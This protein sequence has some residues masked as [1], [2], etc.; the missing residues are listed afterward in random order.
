VKYFILLLFLCAQLSYSA[1]NPI[2]TGN[3][4]GSLGDVRASILT[5]A[6]FQAR[7]GTG[8]VLCDGRDIT[9]SKVASITGNNTLIDARGRFL[10]GKNNG[11]TTALG[12][13]SGEV[14]VGTYQTDAFQD[15]THNYSARLGAIQGDLV[16]GSLYLSRFITTQATTG[17]V[18]GTA[19]N[20]TRP[21]NIT[22][23]YFCKIN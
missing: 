13:P 4:F 15:H 10:R 16:A 14:A 5:E 1:F 17:A 8:W 21:R 23:N 19:T 18:S 11:Q 6:Q 22:I 7:V 9:G 12:N 2:D 3:G 20:E